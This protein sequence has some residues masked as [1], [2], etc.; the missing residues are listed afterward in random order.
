MSITTCKSQTKTQRGF[1][2]VELLVTV[3]IIGITTIMLTPVYNELLTAQRSAYLEK[4]RL[5]NQLIGAA[6]MNYAA[7]STTTGR[8][9]AAYTGA[10]YF[11]TIYDTSNA[12][13][14]AAMNQTGI[15]P[16]EINSDGTTT[17]NIRVYQVVQTLSQ[18]VPLYF[19]SGPLVTIDYDYGA[20]YLTACPKATASCNPTAATGVPGTTPTALTALNYTTWATSGTDGPAF[21][22]SSM[23]I[24]KQMLA[25]TTQRLDKVRDSL[26]GYFRA[27]QQTAAGGDTTNW[28][29]KAGLSAVGSLAG[30][31]PGTN[32]GCRD[33]WYD[34]SNVA[35]LALP[36]VGLAVAEFGK[37]A[38]GGAVEYCR[39]Y[40]PT[41]TTA[42]T[43]PHFAAIR[44][45]ATVSSGIAPSATPGNNIVLT[46]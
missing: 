11:N 27:Q 37:T 39:D 19:Q 15:N 18:S 24:Q 46:F 45:N 21:F 23:P 40:D 4:H 13:L 6:L 26:L 35:V 38:W 44:I 32:Q 1:T 43:V 17:Q 33:G 20:L 42:N 31:T 22:V 10:G 30:A 12:T 8:L 16:S 34:L 9:P 25:T 7:N 28:F 5:N 2:L 3:V 41:I 14:A 29:P 36:A